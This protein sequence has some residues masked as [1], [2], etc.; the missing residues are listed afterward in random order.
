MS[1]DK[2]FDLVM[3]TSG[4]P[5][6]SGETFL[7]EEV[8]Y[9]AEVFERILVC[10]LVGRGQ[11]RPLPGQF[12]VLRP[13]FSDRKDLLFKGL[14]NGV[15]KNA[16]IGDFFKNELYKN[17]R[18]LRRYLPAALLVRG[19]LNNGDLGRMI[20]NRIRDNTVFYFYWAA[21][22]A[23]A[24][25]FL[26]CRENPM[27]ARFHGFD[28]YEESWD[29]YTPF[30]ELLLERLDHLVFISENGKEYLKHKYEGVRDD[31]LKVF[32]LG[33]RDHGRGPVNDEDGV[34]RIVS[35]SGLKPLKRIHLLLEALRGIEDVDV[36][37]TCIGD[38]PEREKL[39][40]LARRLPPNVKATFTGALSHAQ[41]M[42]FYRNNS[43]DLFVNV[44][45]TEG[46]PVSI[47][48]AM[49]FGIPI[50]ATD[51]GGVSELVDNDVG[52]LL[53]AHVTIEELRNS[54]GKLLG[55]LPEERKV[56]RDKARDRWEKTS[57][58]KTNYGEFCRFLAEIASK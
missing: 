13:Q 31:K 22:F 58:A 36:E 24:A 5:Y 26:P 8:N 27:V 14:L 20:N 1:S 9:L 53:D 39:M 10:P 12:E 49:S 48:E 23:Y 25:P 16:F 29:G 28:L 41:V 55:L 42:D 2:P 7:E 4:F 44:S 18:R 51:V 46:L 47:M 45:R 32:R 19:I 40:S 50:L 34:R 3:F 11:Q 21:N 17:A 43:V 56:L 15:F 35:C 57:N 6:G 52:G 38:G 37:Y 54:L 33:T 30:R